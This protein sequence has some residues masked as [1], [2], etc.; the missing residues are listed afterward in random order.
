MNEV[1]TKKIETQT[2]DFYAVL[3]IAL[4]IWMAFSPYNSENFI[5]VANIYS[6]LWILTVLFTFGGVLNIL[7]KHRYFWVYVLLVSTPLVFLGLVFLQVSLLAN[8][9]APTVI[10]CIFTGFY[11]AIRAGQIFQRRRIVSNVIKK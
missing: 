4:G 5:R 10:F 2:L 9:F 7:I 3:V 8:V 6:P 1:Y 11:S